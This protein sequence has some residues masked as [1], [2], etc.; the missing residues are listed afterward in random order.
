MVISVCES[1]GKTPLQIVRHAIRRSREL[2]IGKVVGDSTWCV[3]DVDE[4]EDEAVQ[5]AFE[6]AGEQLEM[7]VSNPCF[8]VWFLLHYTYAEKRMDTCRDVINELRRYMPGYDKSADHFDRLRPF[9]STAV[10]NAERL[11]RS[12]AGMGY[13]AQ[14]RDANPGTNV[15][16]LVQ[17]IVSGPDR[18][19]ICDRRK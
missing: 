12:R 16:R 7:A 1:P 6:L 3:F 10:I 15:H 14:M 2:D 18:S 5:R 19:P 8:E 11:E 17:V 4:C 9:A 13:E